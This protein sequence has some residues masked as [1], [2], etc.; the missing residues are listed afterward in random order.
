M[1]SMRGTVRD[2]HGAALEQA[3]LALCSSVCYGT[4]TDDRGA[5]A[6]EKVPA[7]HYKLE[8]R[9]N[10]ADDRH[11][12]VVYFPLELAPDEDLIMEAPIVLPET[13]SGTVVGAG[14][15]TITIDAELSMRVDS[16]A[17][18]LPFGEM[19]SYLAGVRVAQ[20]DWPPNVPVDDGVVGVWALNPYGMTSTV[21]VGFEIADPLGEAASTSLEVH[22][23]D[24]NTAELTKVATAAVN[25]S[26]DGIATTDSEGITELTWLVVRRAP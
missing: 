10:P 18:T 1:A 8:V 6:Y 12:G 19:D 3:V 25:S 5:F 4:A 11:M 24:A 16:S 9:V 7:D 22:T 26:G 2:T 20:A 21:N 15:Q 23:L 17:L 14:E 13:G